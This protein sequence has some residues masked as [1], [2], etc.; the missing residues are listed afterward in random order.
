[1]RQWF[2]GSAGCEDGSTVGQSC[3]RWRR[4]W[5]CRRA[6][7]LHDCADQLLLSRVAGTAV[8]V[9]ETAA[10]VGLGLRELEE[11]VLLQAELLELKASRSGPAEGAVVEARIDK[12]HV[13]PGPAPASA[14]GCPR[15]SVP[16]PAMALHRAGLA[17]CQRRTLSSAC[18]SATRAPSPGFRLVLAVV[19][20]WDPTVV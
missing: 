11:A 1:M 3:G 18:V 2:A 17:P 20:R 6:G 12:L 5:Q 14:A 19:L 13:R 9:V 15:L 7:E 8:Q 4:L 16:R 10:P